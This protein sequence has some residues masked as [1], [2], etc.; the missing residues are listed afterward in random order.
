MWTRPD[1]AFVLS[2]LCRVTD[3][4]ADVH[5]VILAWV[6]DYMH[7]HNKT[8][9]VG[10]VH[11]DDFRHGNIRVRSASD[12]SFADDR[13]TRRSTCGWWVS[14]CGPKTF[15]PVAW[16]ACLMKSVAI[17]TAE[18]EMGGIQKATR[19]AIRIVML[20]EPML[21]FAHK[22][23]STI[24]HEHETDSK[25]AKGAIDNGGG[26]TALAH[27][28]RTHGTTVA[29]LSDYYRP[30]DRWVQWVSGKDGFLPDGFTKPIEGFTEFKDGLGL[31]SD[32][33][34][35]LDA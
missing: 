7:T 24:E 23:E 5:D 31:K 1:I 27:M 33:V 3:K 21:R 12:A 13:K 28:G 2:I 32:L 19:T 4:W 17:S 18:S 29:W 6:F 11:P 35:F 14:L 15:V 26:S 8:Y 22:N 9:L 10:W 30:L 25:A 34:T 16:G 20:V